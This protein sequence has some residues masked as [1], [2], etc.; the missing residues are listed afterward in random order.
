MNNINMNKNI[1]NI[2]Y[3]NGI[4]DVKNPN[5]QNIRNINMKEGVESN[6]PR[7]NKTIIVK[8]FLQIENELLLKQVR[9]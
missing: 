6:I 2:N 4:I 9:D 7:S 1:D 8:N 5:S 3:N